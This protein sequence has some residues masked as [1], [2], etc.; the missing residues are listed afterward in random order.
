MSNIVFSNKGQALTSSR[1]VAE[2]FD[3]RHDNVLR[4]IRNLIEEMSSNLSPSS[5]SDMNS[6]MRASL[7]NDYFIE[8]TYKD[9]YERDKIEYLL[10]KDGFTLLAMGFRGPKALKFKLDYINAY[11]AMEQALISLK[12]EEIDLAR[13]LA[14]ENNK[15][16]ER[17]LERTE[18]ELDEALYRCDKLESHYEELRNNNLQWVEYAESL[19]KFIEHK[20]EMKL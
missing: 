6:K 12:Q 14:E 7:I 8:S 20:L 4:D 2:V 18:L 1:K 11:N 13:R 16:Y 9:A 19:E 15:V 10:T 3:K 5:Q 17:T